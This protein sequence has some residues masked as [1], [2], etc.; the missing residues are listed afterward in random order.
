M[1]ST[2]IFFWKIIARPEFFT[3]GATTGKT[4]FA[5]IGNLRKYKDKDSRRVVLGDQLIG[6]SQLGN[7]LFI[8]RLE[9]S[10]GVQTGGIS[11]S[12]MTSDYPEAS[13]GLKLGS[14]DFV[15]IT[16]LTTTERGK[17]LDVQIQVDKQTKRKRSEQ[18][19]VNVSRVDIYPFF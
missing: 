9:D 11:Y 16:D 4:T 2:H 18:S 15:S 6:S 10:H 17:Q 13:S 12:G 1:L 14:D 19:P 8:R 7:D 5:P 3:S